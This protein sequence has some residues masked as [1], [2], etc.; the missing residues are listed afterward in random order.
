MPHWGQEYLHRISLEIGLQILLTVDPL[1]RDLILTH[2]IIMQL[3]IN[4]LAQTEIL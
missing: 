1:L 2:H 4:R 3:A